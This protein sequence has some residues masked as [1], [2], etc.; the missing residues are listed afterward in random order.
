MSIQCY[1]VHQQSLMRTYTN[2]D[3]QEMAHPAAIESSSS[4]NA[5]P[6][7]TCTDKDGSSDKCEGNQK[8]SL[9]HG[10]LNLASLA[11]RRLLWSQFSY[12]PIRAKRCSYTDRC[13]SEIEQEWIEEYQ[14]WLAI[15]VDD[16]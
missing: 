9:A 13:S 8:C 5:K 2:A 11:K 10:L 3:S 6:N 15:M 7:H 1:G 14:E 16:W 4:S 12:D